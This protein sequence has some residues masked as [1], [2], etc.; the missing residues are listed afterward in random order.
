MPNY[1]LSLYPFRYRDAVTGKW[2]NARYKAEIHEIRERHGDEFEITG[3]PMIIRGPLTGW[4]D[5]ARNDS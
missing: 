4:F 1:P 5:P 2:R 3:E